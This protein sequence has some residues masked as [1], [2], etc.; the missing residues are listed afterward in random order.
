[1]AINKWWEDDDRQ[2]YWMEITDRDNLGVDLHAPKTDQS[3]N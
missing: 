2:R 1:M 3:G